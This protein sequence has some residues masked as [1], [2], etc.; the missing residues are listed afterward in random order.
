[1]NEVIADNA[2]DQI[3]ISASLLTPRCGRNSGIT[4]L[5]KV[6][7]RVIITCTATIVHIV[8]CHCGASVGSS[9][10]AII[11]PVLRTAM[12]GRSC[13]AVKHRLCVAT[14]KMQQMLPKLGGLGRC[15]CL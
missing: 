12:I 13:E 14:P 2:P 8:N 3:S 11:I 15:R 4:G 1:M 10:S 6:K 5:R 9:G 7:D